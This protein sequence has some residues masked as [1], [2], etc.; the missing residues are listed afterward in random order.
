[1]TIQ[2]KQLLISVILRFIRAFLAGA[3]ATITA[4]SW[5]TPITT[6]QEI[7]TWLNALAIAGVIGGFTGL[8][9]AVDKWIRG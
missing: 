7:G 9:Q 5:V 4:I 2:N 6:W 1:M 3:I 8:F